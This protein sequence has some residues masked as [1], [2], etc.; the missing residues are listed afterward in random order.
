MTRG[1][2]PRT[3]GAGPW[4]FFTRMA[5]AGASGAQGAH[6]MKGYGTYRQQE[7]IMPTAKDIMHPGARWIYREETL[8]R[9]AQLMRELDVGA[10]PVSDQ[11]DR[12]CGMITDRDIV[13]KCVAMGHDPARV[14]CAD[15]CEGT[16]RWVASDAD[17][18]EVLR[19]MRDHHIKRIPVIEDKR[20]VGV[21]SEA[22]LGQHLSDEQIAEFVET[23]YAL[24]G[25]G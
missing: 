16:P 19:E 20:L 3:P 4:R 15:L 14:R 10:L 13:V 8:D 21:I 7:A 17:T 2:G 9:A 12:M 11:N 5:D 1:T 23:V 6:T 22:D 18:A 25:R 24:P